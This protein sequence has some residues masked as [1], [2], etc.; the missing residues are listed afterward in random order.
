[1]LREICGGGPPT[2]EHL[3][4]AQEVG[5]PDAVEIVEKAV[6]VLGVAVANINNFACPD[7]MLIEGKLFFR[8]ENRERL[9]EVARRNLC[10]VI[11]RETQFTFVDPDMFS[12]AMG[13]AAVSI[14]KDLETYVE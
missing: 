5:D 12:G 10:G 13:A 11:R 9:L 14:C 8:Q 2:M 7:R 1:M 6:R 3:L 4:K